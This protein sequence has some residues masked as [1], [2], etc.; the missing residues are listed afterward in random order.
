MNKNEEKEMDNIYEVLSVLIEQIQKTSETF[1]RNNKIMSDTYIQTTNTMCEL[2]EK[3]NKR[4]SRNFIIVSILF[5]IGS[6]G[7][8]AFILIMYLF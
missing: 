1:T 4:D 5:S 2:L 7:V 3:I 6:L 8:F